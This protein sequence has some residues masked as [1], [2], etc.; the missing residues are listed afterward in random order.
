MYGNIYRPN[1]AMELGVELFELNHT[2]H[3]Q[4][5]LIEEY[6]LKAAMYKAFFFGKS[7][8][9]EILQN[10][11]KENYDNC[12]GE[13]DGMCYASW[14]AK[15]IYRTL[16]DMAKQNLITKSEYEFCQV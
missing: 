4:E 14:R 12:V 11:I 13:F 6:R 3:A 16:E 1:R 9:A 5:L 10:Q 8:L 15:A 2:V 7:K